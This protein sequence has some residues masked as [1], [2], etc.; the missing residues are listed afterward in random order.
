[1]RGTTWPLPL[2]CLGLVCCVGC[3]GDG[4]PSLNPVKGKVTR[5]GKPLA[6]VMVTFTPSSGPSSSGLT[7]A[8][9]EFVLLSQTGMAGAVAGTHK[10]MVTVPEI[11]A[12][13][14]QSV[15]QRQ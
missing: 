11:P 3:G 8:S 6:K 9:G 5:A 7:S 14:S 15:R 10:V 2:L 4:G 12:Y 13:S 1:M